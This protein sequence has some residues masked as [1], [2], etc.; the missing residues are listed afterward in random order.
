[1][2]PGWEARNDEGFAIFGD[3]EKAFVLKQSGDGARVA[4]ICRKAEPLVI[5]PISAW[6]TFEKR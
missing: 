2:C 1:M 5:P 4:D 3:A 6:V